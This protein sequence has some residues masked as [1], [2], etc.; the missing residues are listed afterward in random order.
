[1]YAKTNPDHKF[2]RKI[3]GTEE[4][5][6]LINQSLLQNYHKMYSD[7]ISLTMAVIKSDSHPSQM[8]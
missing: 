8:I 6:G 1:M 7:L 3:K 4:L 2:T 5:I